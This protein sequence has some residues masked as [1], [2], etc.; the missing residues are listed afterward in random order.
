MKSESGRIELS[1]KCYDC[2]VTIR[3]RQEVQDYNKLV[4]EYNKVIK[5]ADA[6]DRNNAALIALINVIG[7][8]FNALKL[9]T[10]NNKLDIERIT[11]IRSLLVSFT[12]EYI[13]TKNIAVAYNTAIKLRTT[14]FLKQLEGEEK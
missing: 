13:K 11:S 1:S 3:N 8:N 4:T 5:R 6:L 7:K 9:D 12:T 10:P 2:P 14:T